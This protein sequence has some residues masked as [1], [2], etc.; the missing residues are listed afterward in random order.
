M[1]KERV[2][3]ISFVGALAMLGA[4]ALGGF[5]AGRSLR[6]SVIMRPGLR[7][8][9]SSPSDD[10]TATTSSTHTG[11]T[12]FAGF[13]VHAFE[14][15][16]MEMPEIVASVLGGDSFRYHAYVLPEAS[17][18]HLVI[19]HP[20]SVPA[21]TDTQH[22]ELLRRIRERLTFETARKDTTATP[23]TTKAEQNGCRQR[24]EGYLSYQQ[25]LALAVA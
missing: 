8:I 21:I 9:V 24:L 5:V 16:G 10:V 15:V 13:S 23:P 18:F 1:S 22:Q 6:P 11:S 7:E 17:G 2:A 20:N 3:L 19:H 25:R 14:I 12:H 4:G